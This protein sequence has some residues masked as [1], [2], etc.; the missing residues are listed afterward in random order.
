[1]ASK[2]IHRPSGEKCGREGS[3]SRLAIRSPTPRSEL[4]A[5]D[6]D[7]S[8]TSPGPRALCV[9]D[10]TKVLLDSCPT[11]S[12]LPSGD[13]SYTNIAGS[14]GAVNGCSSRPSADH[15]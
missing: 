10:R 12:C 9:G 13:Q 8:H 6:A 5:G 1:M 15:T 11:K 3:Y 14:L 7:R 2:T 4:A